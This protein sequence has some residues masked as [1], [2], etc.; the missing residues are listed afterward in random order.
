MRETQNKRLWAY[1][2]KYGKIT[3]YEMFDKLN[4]CHPPARIRDL[5]EKYGYDVIVDRW[6]EKPVKDMK[7]GKEI[8]IKQ[9]FKEYFISDSK[10]GIAYASD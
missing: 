10:K 7:N 4:I 8:T 2:L 3:A 1:L 5:R 9:R 6:I